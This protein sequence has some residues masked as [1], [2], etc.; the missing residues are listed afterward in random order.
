MVWKLKVFPLKEASPGVTLAGFCRPF[1][2]KYFCI[3][4]VF[5]KWLKT[6][7][8]GMQQI[9]GKQ[10]KLSQLLA[11]SFAFEDYTKTALVSSSQKAHTGFDT[12]TRSHSE[13]Q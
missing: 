8:Y 10:S 7:S 13:M 9:P 2:F 6:R 11:N 1:L 4:T 12:V 5:R 3:K